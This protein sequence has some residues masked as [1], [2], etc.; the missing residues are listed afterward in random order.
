MAA[1]TEHEEAAVR[2]GLV[3]VT[4]GQPGISRKR[5]GKGWSFH[6]PRGKRITDTK[7]RKRILSL[8]IPPAWTDVWVCP[9]PKGHIQVTARDV[10]GRKQYRYHATYREARDQSKFR[11]L[12]ELS[13]VLPSIRERA[14]KDLRA[15]ELSRRQILATAVML[16]DKTLIR[17]GNEE[18]AKES[19]H[20]G[21]TTLRRKHV[22]VDG[23]EMV[24]S[25][26][27]KSGIQHALSIRD[28]RI[29]KIIQRGQD[30]PGHELFKYLN[31][32]GKRVTITSDDVNRYLGEIAETHITAKDFRTWGGSMLAGNTLRNIGPAP[33]KR[34]ATRN[35]NQAIDAVAERLGNTRTVC[36]N[37]Y[38]HPLLIEAYL[39]G[40]TAPE[41]VAAPPK[42]ARRKQPRA[43]L[44]RDEVAVLQFLHDLG[45]Q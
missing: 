30:L 22:E 28:K 33:T 19:Q 45:A 31:D 6:G 24:F 11:R 10:K 12:F 14:E 39:D 29:A 23:S 42:S 1:V 20:Y 13:E 2:A 16:L 7:A 37:Y 43:A 3:Y 40:K 26:E 5:A 32:D 38:I 18:Y 35:V 34:D 4:D 41:P 15:P 36:R 44:R 27:G 17:V 8:V 9:D 21:L 25:F